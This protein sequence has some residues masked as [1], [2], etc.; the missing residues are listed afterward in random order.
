MDGVLIGRVRGIDL[1]VN[2]SI[3]IIAMLIAWSL[4]ETVLPDAVDGRSE[5][6]YW[7]AGTLTALGLL[8]ALIA[9]ELGH[10]LVALRNDVGVKGITLWMLGG[11]AVLE[12]NPSTPGAAIRIAAAGPAVSAAIGVIGLA[13][14]VPLTGLAG[15]SV[16]W[17]GAMNLA[18]AA[19]NLLPAFPLDGGRLYQAWQWRT[20]GSERDATRR[21][22]RLGLSVGAVLVGIGLLELLLVSTIGGLW[23]MMIGWF[24]REAARAHLRQSEMERPLSDM[25]V[26]QV[27]SPAPVTV[28]SDISLDNFI[29]GVFF[30]GRHAAYPVVDADGAVVGMITL[31]A[32][33]SL[34]PERAA[35]STVAELTVPLDDLV[36]VAPETSVA[37]LMPLMQER[38]ERRALVMDDAGALLGIV[39]PSDV[40]RLVAVVELAVDRVD[41]VG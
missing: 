38:G 21:A 4:A 33:R 31:N 19:F 26:T 6:E 23:L 13:V 30:G 12:R 29:A 27:M 28:L 20:T 7:V 39:S 24:I 1:R 10:S 36:V 32:V 40:A 9:H 5:T 35:H 37:E 22:V 14:A 2:W 3:G 8:A 34:P 15:A 17:F 16:Q 41:H 18:L 11:V 25:H